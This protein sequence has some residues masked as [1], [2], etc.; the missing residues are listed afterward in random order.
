MTKLTLDGIKDLDA[1]KK[2]GVKLPKFDVKAVV[3]NSKNAP[4]WIHVG[5]GN[6]FRGFIASLQQNLL[7]EGLQTSGIQTVSAYDGAIVDEIYKKHDNLTMNVT[8]LPN[9]DVELEVIASIVG[10]YKLNGSAPCD[11]AFVKGLFEKESL[12]LVSF[13]V[14]EKGYALKDLNGNYLDLVKN[15]INGEIK[16]ARHVV[17]I[18]TYLLNARFNAGAYPISLVSMD[19]CSHNGDKLKDAVCDIA[20]KWQEQGKVSESFITYL[21]DESKV[22]FPCSMIDKITPRPDESIA[23]LL[24]QKGFDDLAPHKT[25]RGSFI[26]PFVNAEKPQ[27]LIIEDK[28]PNGRPPLEAAGVLFTDKNGVDLCERMK[29]T[30]CLNP[31]HTSLAIFGCLLGYNKIADEM[32]DKDLV[33]L[34]KRLGYDEG[35]VVVDD[36]KI[37][38]PKD[39]LD[40]VITQRLTNKCLPDSP[41]RIATDTSQKI[42]VRF[43]VTLKSYVQKGISLDSLVAIPLTI[44]GYLRYLLAIDDNGKA[45]AP[46]DDPLLASLQDL[47]KDIKFSD[48]DSVKDNLRPIL[49]NKSIFLVDLYEI[50]LADRVI[51]LFKIMISKEGA[52]RSLLA[53]SL[54]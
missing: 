6:I 37:L 20:K 12:Q 42:P 50:G 17:S 13:T 39:F 16:D 40:E 23:Y 44:A 25:Q 1:Y 31:L 29:V 3:D 8:L 38:N 2:A 5:A 28:F 21:Q 30:T 27:Y 10:G 34:V 9:K 11:E 51:E 24:V 54:S 35:L 19:N 7:N 26:A 32:D 53:K 15:D 22:A 48:V 41:Q 46:S 4:V 43:G 49:S 18:I 45:F 33:A 47:M 14:T 52:V 36:P